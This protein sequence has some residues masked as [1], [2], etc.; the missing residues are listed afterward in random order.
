MK[1]FFK[2]FL[3]ILFSSLLIIIAS[4]ILIIFIILVSVTS[5]GGPFF[6]AP[7]AGK[8]GKPFKIIKFR[9]M[10]VDSEGNGKWNV[11]D[12]DP[13]ITK[14][15]HFLRKSKIDELPQLF[16]VFLGQMSFVGPRPEFV[17]YVALYSSKEMPILEN[18]PGIT[19]WA[20][21]V[22]SKQFEAF[23]N[24]EDPDWCYLH[25]I[26]PLKLDL[27]LYYHD[28]CSIG[29]DI[30]I[31]WWTFIRLIFR[32]KKY[33][34][35]IQ[36]IVDDYD[37]MRE[38]QKEI[39]KHIEYVQLGNSDLKVSRLCFGGCPMGG[40]GW[41]ETHKNDFISAI[42]YAL[43]IGINFFDT[44]DVYGIGESEKTLGEALI[45]R[46]NEAIVATK[47]GVRRKD[48]KS[49]YDNSP[50]WIREALEESLKRLQMD[51]VDLYQVHY[52]DHKTPLEDVVKTLE[53]LVKEG[54]IRYYGISNATVD[55][56][57]AIKESHAHFISLQ[58]EYSLATR[59][60]ENNLL[61]IS[62]ELG[63]TPM[64]WGSLGQGILAGRINKDTVF[65]EGDR[66]LR[67]EYV[68]FHGA[69][70]EHNLQI[71][72]VLK[73][74]AQKYN[75]SVPSIAIR[76]TLDFIPNSVTLVGIKN[77]KQLKDNVEA[78]GWELEKDDIS[79]LQEISKWDE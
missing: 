37:K 25:E 46:R 52:L 23:T 24:A 75:K 67:P 42:R 20:S 28:H 65:A 74:L 69:K 39:K 51:Y 19:D 78:L 6:V 31:L 17:H 11:G 7:R 14:I 50:E 15:G 2:R 70:F 71:V 73:E 21:I 10:R 56:I 1:R 32:V 16:N 76:Y 4:P 48:G 41:G 59:K 22:N 54:K 3:D 55:D 8:G 63:L 53:D 62:K 34:K 43:D 77:P 66:R 72:E 9:S 68:N 47:F 79:R 18:K 26:R 33:P 61:T 64:T 5:K 27:Q 60:N 12:R 45:G 40:Y 36:K 58:D 49:F 35:A 29:E 30:K 38:E 57:A 13:R 44:A